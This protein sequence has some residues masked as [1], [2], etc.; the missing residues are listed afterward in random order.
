MWLNTTNSTITRTNFKWEEINLSV[1]VFREK[2]IAMLIWWAIWDALWIPVE[3]KT[4][5]Y[6][7]SNYGKV[8]NFLDSSLNVF[9]NKWWLT[10]GKKWLISDDTILTFV[11]LESIIETW[12]I[13]FNNL[14]KKSIEA[15]KNFPYW[16]W[17]WTTKALG[18]YEELESE[19]PGADNHIDLWSK[20]SAWNWM[21]MKQS[22]YS[23]YFLSKNTN[24]KD[25]EDNMLLLT[26][27]THWH[28][29]A[30][31]A[32]LVHNNF[33]MELLKADEGLDFKELL[34]Y[35]ISYSKK[36]EEKFLEEWN[37]KISELLEKLLEDNKNWGLNS[38]DEILDK[39]WWW[40]QKI[41][42]SGYVL[43]TIWIVYSIFLNK[44]NFEGL[45]DTINI[46]W[47]TDTFAS[48]IWNMIWAYKWKF[49]TDKFVDWL[50]KSDELLELSEKFWDKLI[51]N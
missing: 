44:Q 9:F 28:P 7:T 20:E 17:W 3:M 33:L 38:Y 24:Y 48:I 50:D 16:F 34:K 31:V 30:I 18:K 8:D 46:G 47:D 40:N 13:E 49:Y 2:V 36:L 29:T 15:Y 25:I 35:L 26:K 12:K 11:W 32:S 19:S 23:A 21:I 43:T 10:S 5:E 51:E 4:K 22:P 27:L 45:L 39:Y 42:S 1:E 14:L 41:Y 37:D 6:I